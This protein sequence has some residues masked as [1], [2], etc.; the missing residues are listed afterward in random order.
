MNSLQED[1][2]QIDFVGAQHVMKFDQNNPDQP[3]YHDLQN[4]PRVDFIVE[5]ENAIFFIEV[6][7]PG[8][9]DAIDVGG[10]KLLKKIVEGTLEASLIEK[11]LFSFFFR[12]AERRLEKS[13]HY[14]S[15]IT[16]ESPLL[17][18][19]ID[20]LERQLT[21]FSKKSVRWDREPLASCQVHNIETWEAMFPD[22]PVTRLAPAAAAGG[23]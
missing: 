23:A 5:M 16:L 4:M 18:P 14:V 8:R 3:D 19:I 11:Y 9:P 17:Q 22:W 2:L 10:A 7:D 1:G 12:W 21:N 20:G 13:V 6:K 15:L